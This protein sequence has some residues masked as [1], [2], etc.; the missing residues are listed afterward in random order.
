MEDALRAREGRPT[1]P[2]ETFGLMQV[3]LS[4]TLTA[5]WNSG[6]TTG[7]IPVCSGARGRDVL[8]RK[9]VFPERLLKVC[10]MD[11]W[12]NFMCVSQCEQMD[13]LLDASFFS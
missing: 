11:S 1:N 10:G 3:A 2:V 5:Q 13:P 6:G 12:V 4:R 9:V 7:W 8:K